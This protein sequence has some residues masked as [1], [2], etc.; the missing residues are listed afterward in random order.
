MTKTEWI[1]VKPATARYVEDL[2]AK[3]RPRLWPNGVKKRAHSR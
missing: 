2:A 1:R 3:R